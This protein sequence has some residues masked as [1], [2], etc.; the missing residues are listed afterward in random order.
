M[1]IYKNQKI[2]K[3]EKKNELLLSAISYPL[4]AAVYSILD[5]EWSI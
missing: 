3:R 1:A 5:T 4:E 2:S